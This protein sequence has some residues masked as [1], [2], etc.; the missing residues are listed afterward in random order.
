MSESS[1]GNDK[2]GTVALVGAGEYLPAM[3]PV[4]RALLAS[5]D[6]AARVVVL[7]TA[8]VPDGSGV[9]QRWT[10]MG[11]EH[12]TRLGVK[13]QPVMLLS[14]SDAENPAVAEQISWAS[15]VYLSGGKPRY[16]LETLQG[17][18]AWQA[19]LRVYESGG[20]VTGCSAGA[21][22]LGGELFDVPQIWR[23]W[24]ALGLVPGILVIPHFD[25]VPVAVSSLLGKWRRGSTLVGI[26]AMTALV[27]HHGRYTV[28]GRGGGDGSD[29]RG[30]KALP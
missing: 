3:E 21:M 19:I 28:C 18:P 10:Q 5:L 14:R 25:E 22:V 13:A 4:D 8:S 23:R 24:P 29:T 1:M 2:S 12:F 26:D 27:G 30:Q 20:V 6:T 9:S 17:T 16:L 11:I 15:F 7:P